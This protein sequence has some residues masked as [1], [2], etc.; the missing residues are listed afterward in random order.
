L[1]LTG[2]LHLRKISMPKP[3]PKYQPG[4]Y[5]HFYNRGR[6][7]LSIFNEP[8]NYIYL[9]KKAK[10]YLRQFDLTLVA[11]CLMPNHYH[12]LIRQYGEHAAGLLPQR[13]FNSYTKAYNK[14]YAHSGTL[15]EGPYRVKL[16]ERD[17]HLL[18]LCRYIH[19]NPVKD[20]LVSDPVDWPYSNYSEWMRLRDGTLYD[21]AFVDDHFP[22][23]ETYREFVMDG[24]SSREIA[25]EM[26]GYL[27]ELE[28]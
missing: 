11:Y 13:V 26:G 3:R 16:V 4:C 20:G 5:Y 22:D 7:R 23:I 1:H 18:H 27:E 21:Q 19:G 14:R 12:F 17:S 15:F 9:L 28:S 10:T 24:L 8:D 25:P 6:S 2:A